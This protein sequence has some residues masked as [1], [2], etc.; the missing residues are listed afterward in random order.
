[1]MAMYCD[2]DNRGSIVLLK[3]LKEEALR[4][5]ESYVGASQLTWCGND[6]IILSV[7]DQVVIITPGDQH[8]IDLAC[9]AE[10]IFCK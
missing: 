2:A 5:E 6:S 10:G 1:M 7:S 4:I 8:N 9:R 3:N